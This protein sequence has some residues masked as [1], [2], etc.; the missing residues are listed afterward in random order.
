MCKSCFNPSGVDESVTFRFLVLGWGTTLDIA[1][2]SPTQRD[3]MD[4]LLTGP[5]FADHFQLPQQ[6]LH[7]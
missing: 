7:Q 6:H 1:F 4:D 3:Q 2:Q 5:G